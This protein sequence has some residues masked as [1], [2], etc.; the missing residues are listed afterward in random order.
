M[1]KAPAFLLILLLGFSVVLMAQDSSPDAETDWDNYS[2]ELY[3]RG[4]QTFSISLGVA[5]PT[6]FLNNGQFL[7]HNIDP[8]V[9]GSGFL[10]YNYYFGPRL[11]VGGE[12]GGFVLPTL[13]NNTIYI[14]M[15]GGRVGTQFVYGRFEF[16]LSVSL[17]MSWQN[18]L[19]L[20]YYGFYVRANAAA[21][22][23]VFNEWSFGLKAGWSWLPQWTNDSSKNVDGNFFDI[24]ISARYHF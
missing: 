24:T 1:H 12:A 15:L 2:S 7:S 8:P 9:G 16:P 4:D 17:G 10:V 20:G 14:V 19:N 6:L 23:R 3:V 22:F 5:F 11:F 13:A 18:Y 21:Y